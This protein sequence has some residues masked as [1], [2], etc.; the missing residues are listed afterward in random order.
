LA[1]IREVRV[2]VPERLRSAVAALDVRPGDRVLEVGGGRGVAA[3]LI[4]ERLGEGRLLAIDRSETATA[5]AAA[6]NAAHVDAGRAVF[7]ALALADLGSDAG[8]F[9]K[10]LAVNVNVFWT[11]PATRELD[12][13]RRVLAP[14]G[15]LLLAYEPPSPD[16]R[17]RLQ[18]TLDA[19][20]RA[21]GW[22]V[23]FTSAASGGGSATPRAGGVPLGAS[24]PGP[25]R[26]G[27]QGGP[28]PEVLLAQATASS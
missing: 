13:L 26:R 10:A 3:G 12:V 5:A 23:M 1:A 19:H 14:G 28:R 21:A 6:R 15:V 11:G 2:G 25:G 20:L 16:R 17:A 24:G 7:T 18:D 27:G 8:P 4:C 9:D 22:D